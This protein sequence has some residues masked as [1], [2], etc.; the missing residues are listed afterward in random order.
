MLAVLALLA[1]VLA[2]FKVDL[3][4]LNLVA[5]GLAFLAAHLIFPWTPWTRRP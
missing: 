3:A 4:G 5:L 1:F 2:I